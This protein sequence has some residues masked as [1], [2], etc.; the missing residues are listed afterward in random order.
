MHSVLALL[1][2]TWLGTHQVHSTFRFEFARS[3]QS[4]VKTLTEQ[5]LK[6]KEEAEQK[7]MENYIGHG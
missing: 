6:L 7:Q 1:T 2:T 4:A 3:T 5:P